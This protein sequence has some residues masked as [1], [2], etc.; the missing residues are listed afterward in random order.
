MACVSKSIR[1]TERVWENEVESVR[2]HRAK[3]LDRQTDSIADFHACD[4]TSSQRAAPPRTPCGTSL[5]KPLL[6]HHGLR[7]QAAPAVELQYYVVRPPRCSP[8][9]IYPNDS[10]PLTRPRLPRA[11]T[12]CAS[13]RAAHRALVHSPRLACPDTPGATSGFARAQARSLPRLQT[14]ADDRRPK[15]RKLS[16]DA[17]L[18]RAPSG[19]DAW[20]DEEGPPLSLAADSAEVEIEGGSVGDAGGRSRASC[21]ALTQAHAGQDVRARSVVISTTSLSTAYSGREHLRR[22]QEV[23][24]RVEGGGVWRSRGGVR[25]RGR[26]LASLHSTASRA[27]TRARCGTYA[28]VRRGSAC[29][30]LHCCARGAMRWKNWPRA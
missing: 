4:V 5:L 26:S 3:N 9:A 29:R 15:E 22:G 17:D 1:A 2:T 27:R 20:K 18:A 10:N 24:E 7:L 25:G 28:S 14:Q 13:A 8:S 21:H 6:L 12:S 16:S 19:S 30:R 23:D 11:R